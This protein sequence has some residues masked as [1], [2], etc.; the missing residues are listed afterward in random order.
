M[1]LTTVPKAAGREQENTVAAE[2][3]LHHRRH[4]KG[5]CR[6]PVVTC[7]KYSPA[8]ACATRS[9]HRSLRFCWGLLPTVALE[10]RCVCAC[11]RL[12]LARTLARV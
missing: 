12:H 10:Q 7:T 8:L 4:M 11:G 1:P 9:P 3:S 2:H 6:A 5:T